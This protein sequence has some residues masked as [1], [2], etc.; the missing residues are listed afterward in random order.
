MAHR[1]LA[2]CLGN[3][4]RSPLAH[5][6][7][8][9]TAAARG[10]ALEVESAGTGDYHVGKPPDDRSIAEAKRHGLDISHQR[11]QQFQA[12]DFDK[13]DAILVMDASNYQEVLR[14]AATPAHRDKLH[15]IMNFA[16][17]GRNGQVPDP[18]W[19]DDGFA[20]VYDMLQRA[21]NGY[22][23]SISE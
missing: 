7:L 20:G 2:V 9:H 23:D 3:I 12:A 1:V 18:Y 5:A 6:L 22:L 15:L 10:I 8:E 11:A 14:H 17:P 21:V 13:F 16:N 4:C 19:D